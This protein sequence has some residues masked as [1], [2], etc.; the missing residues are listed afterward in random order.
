MPN[1]TDNTKLP[2]AQE[3]TPATNMPIRVGMNISLEDVNNP[4]IIN[5]LKDV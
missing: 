1:N 2:F 5:I 3:T 4:L